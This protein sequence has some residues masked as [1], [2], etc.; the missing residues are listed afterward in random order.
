MKMTDEEYKEWAKEHFKNKVYSADAHPLD[1]FSPEDYEAWQSMFINS[2]RKERRKNRQEYDERFFI[3]MGGSLDAIGPLVKNVYRLLAIYG[4]HNADAAREIVD[5]CLDE[6]CPYPLRD[7]EYEPDD[8]IEGL[9]AFSDYIIWDLSDRRNP[10]IKGIRNNFPPEARSMVEE[11]AKKMRAMTREQTA[12]LFRQ[13]CGRKKTWDGAILVYLSE[14]DRRE[15]VALTEPDR[16]DIN[17]D[18]KEE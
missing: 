16:K 9:P 7:F 1:Y 15:L 14:E 5:Y 3:D 2:W 11:D 10:R 18:E 17:E 12:E 8:E 4:L 13:L 6:F